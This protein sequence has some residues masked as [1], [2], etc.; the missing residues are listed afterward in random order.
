MKRHFILTGALVILPL[1][2]QARFW[3]P[4]ETDFEF[5]EYITKQGRRTDA[6][7]EPVSHQG[8]AVHS[9]F[10]FCFEDGGHALVYRDAPGQQQP[11]GCFDLE[12][13][14]PAQHANCVNF[15]NET[16][17]RASFPL[18]YVTNGKK[19]CDI[20]FKCFVESIRRRGFGKHL[21]FTNKQVQIITADT[22]GFRKEGFVPFFGCPSWQIDADRGFIWIFSARRRTV[23]SVT[24]EFCNNQYI[25][26]KYRIPTLAEGKEVTLGVDD[27]LDQVLFEFDTYFTQGGCAK[28]GKIYFCFGMNDSLNTD[29]LTPQRIRV[30]DTDSRQISAAY[31]LDPLMSEEPE[32]LYIVGESLYMNTNSEKIYRLSLPKEDN[33]IQKNVAGT[34]SIDS[35]K[36]W[37]VPAPPA[38]YRPVY[39]S[40]YSRHGAR[41][42]DEDET[43]PAVYGTLEKTSAAG[44]L[45]EM[46]RAL[47]ERVSGISPD[48]R[49]RTGE[50]TKLGYRQWKEAAERVSRLYPEIF[51]DGRP[52]IRAEASN[53]MRVA[54]SMASF[55]SEMKAIWP[56]SRLDM[57]VSTADLDHINPYM[58][59]SPLNTE[60]DQRI[61]SR[62]GAWYPIF[63]EI[64][65]S[66]IDTGKLMKRLFLDPSEAGVDPF[67]FGLNFY[68]FAADQNSLEHPVFLWDIFT[69]EEAQCWYEADMA[70]LYMQKGRCETNLGRGWGLAGRIFDHLVRKADEEISEGGIRACFGHDVCIMALLA[71]LK[72]DD[73]GVEN[74]DPAEASK[75]W[76]GW[77][78]PMATSL[79]F[80]FYSNGSDLL[81]RPALNGKALSLPLDFTDDHFYN[82]TEFKRHYDK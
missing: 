20:E 37:T 53:V 24:G 28:D 74:I 22:T 10:V 75:Y 54:M 25:A 44:N 41:Y 33:D 18:L 40:S 50:L 39:I 61:R 32:D 69:Q 63:K 17:R 3:R 64:V 7:G 21:R 46:G 59:T 62:E 77:K 47:W 66:R 23:P 56:E 27:V 42:I 12:S 11:V 60:L 13:S 72:A 78:V 34:Y 35:F 8:M 19:D 16:A 6:Q 70:R 1:M 55:C 15:G 29:G 71:Y 80:V 14:C 67:T 82:W 51:E 30:Y 73:W 49:H 43:W 48:M 31:E 76:K 5:E 36:D 81:V 26:T 9:G 4:A 2:A 38:G 58:K 45:T 79:D 52:V 65:N 57:Y 68:Y